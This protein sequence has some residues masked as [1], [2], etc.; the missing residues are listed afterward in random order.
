MRW[1]VVTKCLQETL[2]S[3]LLA[4]AWLVSRTRVRRPPRPSRSKT[5]PA[6]RRLLDQP[7]IALV[8]YWMWTDEHDRARE[9]LDDWSSASKT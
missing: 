9:A 1:S 8:Q 7:L 2:V 4:E 6:D 5:A 3:K